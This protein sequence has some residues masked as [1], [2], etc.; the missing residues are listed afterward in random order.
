MLTNMAKKVLAYV[1]KY[2]ANVLTAKQKSRILGQ[3]Y[4]LRGLAYY[5][6]ATTFKIVPVITTPPADP[7]EYYSPT[8]TE[9]VLWNQIFSDFQAAEAN[10][11]I[12]YANVIGPDLGQKGRAT[13]GAAAGMLG[14]AY[15]YRKDYVKAGTQFEKF[16]TGGPLSGV[17]SL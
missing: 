10:L 9:D 7:S 11:P 14:K 12:S 1:S 2:D 17:Y 4:F 3:A 6:L 5:N 15:L 13:K 8:A 16:F